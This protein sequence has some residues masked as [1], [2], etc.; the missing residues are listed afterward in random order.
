[1]EA[2]KIMVS[3][4]LANGMSP[5]LAVI[6]RDVLGLNT[7]VQDV[8]KSF[9]RWGLAAG[10]VA[11]ILGG[12]AMLGSMVKLVEHGKEF[13]HQLEL[14]KIAN[15]SNANIVLN[16]AKAYEVSGKV[17]TTTVTDNMKH[18]RELSY[19]FGTDEAARSHLEKSVDVERDPEFSQGR[20]S[21][22]GLGAGQ[23]ARGKGRD[24]GLRRLSVTSTS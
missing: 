5:I 23:G 4:G 16:T 9:G 21:G 17:L 8:E 6:G 11:G 14:M 12:S 20:R 2:Y 18:L 24:R 13:V 1:M 19:A 10:G 7:K 3:I 15:V 22:S